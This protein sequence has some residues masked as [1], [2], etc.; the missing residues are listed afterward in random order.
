MGVPCRP[1]VENDVVQDRA[2]GPLEASTSC[3]EPLIRPKKYLGLCALSCSYKILTL[4]RLFRSIS[5]IVEKWRLHS[6]REYKGC[7]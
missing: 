4:S 6:P 2:L 5:W 7:A 3:F 1:S